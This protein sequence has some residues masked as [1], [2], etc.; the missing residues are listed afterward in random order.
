MAVPNTTTFSL[1]DVVDEIN[2]TTDD[3]VDCVSDATSGSYDGAY[4]SS[5]ATSL[6]EF[7][8]Y[9]GSSSINYSCKWG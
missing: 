4:Y 9:G 7:R 2:P 6:L 5:P 3:L 1:Q 8:N